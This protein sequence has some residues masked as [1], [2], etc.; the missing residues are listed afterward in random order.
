MGTAPN[1]GLGSIVENPIAQTFLAPFVLEASGRVIAGPMDPSLPG[2]PGLLPR[3][4]EKRWKR[5]PPPLA[6]A[7]KT[8]SRLHEAPEIHMA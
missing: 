5:R 7:V 8:K 3:N 6:R 1:A 2:I 4:G